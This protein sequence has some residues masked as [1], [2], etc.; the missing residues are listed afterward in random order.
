L[1]LVIEIL[2]VSDAY[3]I[4]FPWIPDMIIAYKYEMCSACEIELK[5]DANFS[6][7]GCPHCAKKTK[8]MHWAKGN[9]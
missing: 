7:K 1:V 6:T 2:K 9:V 3:A 8:M 5:N 4:N